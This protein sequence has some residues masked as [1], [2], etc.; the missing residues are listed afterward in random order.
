MVADSVLMPGDALT[1]YRGGLIAAAAYSAVINSLYLVPSL[2]MLQV[3]DRVLTS[4]NLTTLTMLTVLMLAAYIA[5]AAL[6]AI[7]NMMLV[8]I[9]NGVDAALSSSVFDAVFNRYALTRDL[10]LLGRLNDLSVIRSFIGGSG[11][12]SLFDA[13]WIPIYLFVVYL[14]HPYFALLV[15]IGLLILVA[16]ALLT[17][18][19]TGS[20]LGQASAFQSA[21]N[22]GVSNAMH[23]IDAISAM[24]MT[25]R[26]RERWSGQ[27]LPAAVLQSKAADRASML[28]SVSKF[29]RIT[30]QS[31]ILCLGAALVIAGDV[32]PGLMIAASIL[33]SRALAPVEQLIASW[34]PFVG[35][36]KSWAQLKELLALA[37]DR[38]PSVVLPRPAGR[39]LLEQVSFRLSSGDEPIL[40]NVSL[41]VSPGEIVGIIGP[42]ASG[43]STIAKLMVG[44]CKPSSGVVR[45]DGF[46]LAAWSRD[47][48]GPHLGYLPQEVQLMDGTVGENISRFATDATSE[49]IIAAA[50][51]AHAHDAIA[52]LPQGYNTRVGIG[53]ESLSG[54]QRQR[55][56]LARALYGEPALLVLDEP[57]SN[58][59]EIG[60][61]ALQ[62]ALLA[63]KSSGVSIVLISHRPGTV[64]IT[65]RLIVLKDG[66]VALNGPRD[67]VLTTL[68]AGR[69]PAPPAKTVE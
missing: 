63:A 22:A 14:M 34:K 30:L 4:R 5:L 19:T 51:A 46:D 23:S 61:K 33:A 39:L 36:R 48:L 53:G 6:N 59:D 64:A 20:K 55:V 43:K 7:R 13:P 24:G 69:A 67:A 15:L 31:A 54:G 58:L 32:T 44:A 17:E 56:A 29:V 37:D 41:S 16:L 26:V 57:N 47:D 25:A 62:D 9:G 50:K 28:T 45:L 2:Y 40:Q 12:A 42:S 60:E 65:D 3:Y 10:R 52:R 11:M 18:S 68:N 66:R 35:F 49:S 27:T 38:G 8:R 21:A 1:R